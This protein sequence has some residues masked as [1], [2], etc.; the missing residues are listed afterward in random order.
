MAT[1]EELFNFC[2]QQVSLPFYTFSRDDV[3]TADLSTVDA[4]GYVNTILPASAAT[5]SE[6]SSK[7]RQTRNTL[8][9][10]EWERIKPELIAWA[11]GMTYKRLAIQ[12]EE[13]FGLSVRSV[14]NPSYFLKHT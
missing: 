5:D 2:D 13:D 12:V 4:I 3:Q 11:P 7:P 10:S 8:D 14:S 9:E 6:I 1:N